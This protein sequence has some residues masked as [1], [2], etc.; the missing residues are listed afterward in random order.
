VTWFSKRNEKKFLRLT[1][2]RRHYPHR[3]KFI[4]TRHWQCA[5]PIWVRGI[6][7]S[8]SV[9]HAVGTESWEQA[10]KAVD[11]WK[12]QGFVDDFL[13]EPAPPVEADTPLTIEQAIEEFFL[14]L[15]ARQLMPDSIKK[16]RPVL[17]H[18]CEFAD[19]NG[20]RYLTEFDPRNVSKF[21]N[22]W[23]QAP[24]TQSKNLERLK[25]FFNYCVSMGTLDKSPAA[26]L[27]PPEYDER[28]T[29]PFSNE[30]MQKTLASCDQHTGLSKKPGGSEAARLKALVLLMR[31]SGLRIGDAL[32]FTDDPTP[33]RVGRKTI[34]PPHIIEG[35]RLFLYTQKAGTPVCV[36][37]PP[38]FFEALGKVKRQSERYY[39]WSGEGKMHSRIADDC[40]VLGKMFR[41]AGITGGHAHRF[42]DTF[43]VELL[44]KGVDLADVSMLLGHHSIRVTEK[45]YSP[46]VKARQ[47]RLELAVFKTW[48]KPRENVV[49]FPLAAA[50]QD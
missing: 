36:P 46:W 38:V 40:R 14:D 8:R 27:R 34:V 16:Y 35:N 22:T 37:L 30:E 21:R 41:R 19:K 24:I 20:F 33:I 28:P 11:R 23:K 17:K 50:E 18:L 29:L 25:T 6:L 48:D 13:A 39:F 4:S 42:R 32:R 43:A 44:L 5:C 2:Y 15:E 49:P 1:L 31:Y 10:Q 26:V 12:K 47:D 7:G 45:H 9:R 3:C